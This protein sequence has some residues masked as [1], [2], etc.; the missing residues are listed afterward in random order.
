VLR[1][2]L[3]DTLI[4]YRGPALLRSISKLEDWNSHNFQLSVSVGIRF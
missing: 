2:D 1:I 3:G 4:R